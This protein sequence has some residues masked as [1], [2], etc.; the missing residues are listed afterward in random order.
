VEDDPDLGTMIKLMLEHKG[1]AVTLPERIEQTEQILRNNNIDLVLMD[2]LLS[3]ANGMNICTELKSDNETKH[4]PVMMISAHP[5]AKEL[6]L[7]AGAD[8]F[9]SKPFDIQDLIFKVNTLVYKSKKV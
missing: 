2:M 6:C 3:G 7:G 1:F 5:E 9:I 4:I 8:D